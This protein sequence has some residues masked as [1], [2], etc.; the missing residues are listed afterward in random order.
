MKPDQHL[1]VCVH[2]RPEG[3]PRGSCS[4]RGGRDVLSALRG[5]IFDQEL[6]G[7]VKATGTTCLGYCE[8]GVTVVM[9]PDKTW[10][11]KVTK[12]DAIDL[13]EE[14]AMDGQVVERLKIPEADL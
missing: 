2:E 11:C 14:H 5:E 7:K 13:I 6:S 9:Y 12:D 8:Q 10:Y 3:D 4:L 1:F